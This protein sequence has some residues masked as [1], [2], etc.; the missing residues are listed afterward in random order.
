[1]RFDFEIV[2]QTNRRITVRFAD[3]Q[4]FDF[5]IV[6]DSTTNVRWQWSDGQAFN[7]VATE[8]TFEPYASKSYSVIWP[9]T[10]ADGTQL[11]AGRYQARGSLVF[12][13]FKSNPLA[14]NRLG[15]DLEALTVH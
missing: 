4:I 3:S 14:A 8:L 2:N 7:P 11:P 5:L 6:T 9:G 1:M 12:D 10:L 13:G 15:S